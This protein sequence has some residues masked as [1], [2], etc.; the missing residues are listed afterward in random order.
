MVKLFEF[1]GHTPLLELEVAIVEYIH[2]WLTR[3]S[4]WLA[5]RTQRSSLTSTMKKPFTPRVYS[6]MVSI[7]GWERNRVA[8]H[9]QCRERVLRSRKSRLDRQRVAT[10]YKNTFNG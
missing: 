4:A 10:P 6:T 2:H 7:R 8:S 5:G 1:N 3:Q 9:N